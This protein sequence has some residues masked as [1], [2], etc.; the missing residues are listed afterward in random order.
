M[1]VIISWQSKYA[2]WPLNCTVVSLCAVPLFDRSLHMY[3]EFQPS[4]SC[5]LGK[6]RD[7]CPWVYEQWKGLGLCLWC[8]DSF[9]SVSTEHSELPVRDHPMCLTDRSFVSGGTSQFKLTSAPHSAYTTVGDGRSSTAPGHQGNEKEMLILCRFK[10]CK[11]LSLTFWP[12]FEKN[13]K[14]ES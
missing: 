6:L 11:M 10:S 9:P 4:S 12:W 3:V 2:G 5:T 14:V 1:C 8:V 7:K 13:N